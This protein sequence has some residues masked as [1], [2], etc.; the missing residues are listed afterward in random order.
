MKTTNVNELKT[1]IKVNFESMAF[2]EAM[3]AN[4][5]LFKEYEEAKGKR[6]LTALVSYYRTKANATVAIEPEENLEPVSESEAAEPETPAET[7]EA[8]TEEKPA[9]E[10][11]QTGEQAEEPYTF[12]VAAESG[13]LSEDH[14]KSLIDSEHSIVNKF[15]VIREYFKQESDTQTIRN[16]RMFVKNDGDGYERWN[17]ARATANANGIKSYRKPGNFDLSRDG[18]PVGEEYCCVS[19]MRIKD[20]FGKFLFGREGA[21]RLARVESID[22][23]IM[24]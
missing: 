19:V 4:A 18:F 23:E 22:I 14:I 2:D 13:H 9:N 10:P 15:C 20:A 11:E 21:T 1:Q 12:D 7:V 24:A 16:T 5:E 6:S 8:P 3:S 17:D